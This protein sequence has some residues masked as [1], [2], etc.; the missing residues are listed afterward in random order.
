MNTR[1]SFKDYIGHNFSMHI[2]PFNNRKAVGHPKLGVVITSCND[3]VIGKRP[4]VSIRLV[5]ILY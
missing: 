5:R 1:T 4:G 2:L 3:K